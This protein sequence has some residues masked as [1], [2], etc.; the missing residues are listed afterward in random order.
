MG[1]FFV[2]GY[3]L[4][5]EVKKDPEAF[6]WKIVTAAGICGH[7]ITEDI[8]DAVTEVIVSDS[9]ESVSKVCEV[10]LGIIANAIGVEQYVEKEKGT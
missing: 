6:L 7:D 3:D 1:N 5:Q 2:N 10:M 8:K 9:Y 4:Y